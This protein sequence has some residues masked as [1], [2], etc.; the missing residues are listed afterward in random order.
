M[1]DA[2]GQGECG[3]REAAD[4]S[5]EQ[6]KGAAFSRPAP[7]LLRFR[8]QTYDEVTSTNDMVKRAIEKGEPE[9]LAVGALAQ[10]AGYGR[11]G[12]SWQSPAGGMY[13]SL[14]LRPQVSLAQLPTLSLVAGMA[15]RRAVARFAAPEAAESV[16]I[17]WPN[18]V[19]YSAVADATAGRPTLRDADA[20]HLAPCAAYG[21]YQSTLGASAGQSGTP[22]PR[23]LTLRTTSDSLGD[24]SPSSPTP[25]RKL[26]GIS[27]ESHAGGICVGIGVNVHAPTSGA[28]PSTGGKNVPAYVADLAPARS[29]RAPEPDLAPSCPPSAADLTSSSSNHADGLV[30]VAPAFA[31]QPPTVPA[32]RQAVLDAFAELYETWRARGFPALLPEYAAHEALAGQRVAIANIDGSSTVEG[33]VQGVDEQGRLLVV[34]DGASQPTAV[35]SGEAH[36]ILSR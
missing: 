14:L 8:L 32:V 3:A 34:P 21:A 4:P 9:G 20:P 11:Q 13:V 10:T 2:H 5:A 35:A 36:I 7:R 29:L 31:L 25:F 18:D 16:R 33:V 17:K 19:V 23:S 6:A 30:P 15:V 27:L 26:A 24:A 1:S 22:Q 12:R 28:A